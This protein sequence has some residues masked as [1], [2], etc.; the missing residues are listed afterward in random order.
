MNSNFE[1]ENK[2]K[3]AKTKSHDTYKTIKKLKGIDN[4]C[5]NI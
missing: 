5:Y 1:I 2:I 3:T 4:Y